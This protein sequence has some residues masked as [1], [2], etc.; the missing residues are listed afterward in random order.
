MASGLRR[1]PDQLSRRRRKSA[2]AITASQ[3]S[4]GRVSC[5]KLCLTHSWSR[6]L[7]SRYA[8]R[9]P[10][11]SDTFHWLA[12][13]D[14]KSTNAVVWG[15][16]FGNL[17]NEFVP[18]TSVYLEMTDGPEPLIETVQEVLSGPPEDVIILEGRFVVLVAS[19]HRSAVEKGL[20]WLDL[21]SS[22]GIGAVVHYSIDDVEVGGGESALL[23]TYSRQ[24]DGESLPPE[25]KHSLGRWLPEQNVNVVARRFIGESGA[26]KL[27]GPSDL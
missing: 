23:L 1:V 27:F 22:A 26:V 3:V 20:L 18:Q 11:A 17:L 2:S 25:F 13:Y 9:G 8:T 5:M 14:G 24:A 4:N 16:R 19:R 7:R 10:A 12:D 6:S 15:D 21:E